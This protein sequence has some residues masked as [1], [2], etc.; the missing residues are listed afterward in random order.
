LRPAVFEA[1]HRGI[2][3]L[4]WLHVP[5]LGLFALLRGYGLTHAVAEAS[6]VA[7]FAAGGTLLRGREVRSLVTALGLVV[8]SAVLVHLWTGA[9][10]GHFHFFVVMTVLALYQ[11]WLPFI[12]ALAFIVLQHGLLGLVAA[13]SVYE[14][15]AGQS[16]PWGWAAIHGGFVLA[17]CVAN[18]LSWHLTEEEALHDV[19]TGLP[20]RAHLLE[21]LEDRLRHPARRTAL[22]FLDLD[23]FKDVNDGFGHDTG[24]ALLIAVARRLSGRV[25]EAEV[26][27]RLGG[28]EFAVVLRA[29]DEAAALAAAK[30]LLSA[31]EDPFQVRDLSLTCGASV[32][33]AL[34]QPGSDG[35][36][37]LQ[38]ADLAMYVAKSG[39]GS[40]CALFEPAMRTRA[41]RR[42]ALIAE[43]PRALADQEFQ[44]HYQPIFGL[45]DGRT[46]GMEALVRWQ[47]PIAGSIAPADF[48]EA[49]EQSGYIVALGEQVLRTACAQAAAWRQAFPDDPELVMSVNL[50][51]RQLSEPDLL[52]VVAQVLAQ[53][54]LSPASLCLEITEGA[55]IDDLEQ[56]LRALESLAA[57]GVRLALDDFGTGYSSLAYLQRMPV[58]VLKIDRSF[59][60]ALS[61][62][63]DDTAIV[64]AVVTL[65]H[66]LG[67]SVTAE[68]IETPEQLDM[69][70][71]TGCDLGQG[72]LKARPVPAA[73]ATAA[74]ARERGRVTVPTPRPAAPAEAEQLRA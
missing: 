32:G 53:T 49:A 51:P 67:L 55:L 44:V 39:G 40:R 5:A 66:Q 11:S 23:G 42:S 20:N 54:G 61:S 19:L 52:P 56:A 22:L 34:A 38:D 3:L 12:G 6:L 17:S 15:A 8:A 45:V 26:L 65:A 36:S 50:S 7:A 46:V 21:V 74:L 68:G 1:R 37:L 10:E 43:F 14:H 64:G 25:R 24:D 71:K 41:A 47:H 30:R 62:P 13:S 57:M 33:I 2:V 29:E 48:I 59:V 63:G 60:A 69:L 58:H 72:F 70:R 35:A 31:F 18:L 28:D 4:L 27:G 9:I 16:N 73:A